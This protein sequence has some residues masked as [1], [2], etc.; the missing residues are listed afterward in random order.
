LFDT[1]LINQVLDTLEVDHDVN[2]SIVNCEV[3]PN[4]T[5]GAQHSRILLRITGSDAE[6]VRLTA[7]AVSK[8]VKKHPRAEGEVNVLEEVSLCFF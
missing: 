2:F 1:G 8:M 6:K 3:R 4:S 5:N 7:E